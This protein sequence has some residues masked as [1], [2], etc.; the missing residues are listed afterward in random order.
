MFKRI[1]VPLD[2]SPLAEKAL[3]Y[4][5]NLARQNDAPIYLGWVIQMLPSGAGPDPYLLP[6]DISTDG[7]KKRAVDYLSGICAELKEKNIPCTY[8]VSEN[9]SISAGI[10]A[11]ATLVKADLIVKTSYG[12]LGINRWFNGNVAAEILQHAPCPLLLIKI[13][14]SDKVDERERAGE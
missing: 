8:Q 3:F 14:D 11:L 7:E 1:F 9:F 12:R 2:G 10:I 6:I 13:S 4:A 5:T